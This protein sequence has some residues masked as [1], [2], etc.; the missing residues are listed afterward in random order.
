MKWLLILLLLLPST[1]WAGWSNDED[2]TGTECEDEQPNPTSQRRCWWNF[3]SADSTNNSN[4]LKV[5]Q[6][7]NWSIA[8][9]PDFDGT[10]TTATVKPYICLDD[11]CNTNACYN[12]RN[13]V[14]NSTTHAMYGAD[15]TWI[16]LDIITAAGSGEN[17]RCEFRCNQ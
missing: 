10:G 5:D 11:A 7:E 13:V 15:G 1:A 9:V 14:F 3:T 8:C 17:G 6:C 4:L 16:C 12:P 2:G